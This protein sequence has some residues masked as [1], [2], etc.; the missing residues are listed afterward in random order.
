MVPSADAGDYENTEGVGNVASFD[1]GLI[2]LVD[3]PPAGDPAFAAPAQ[4][5]STLRDVAPRFGIGGALADHKQPWNP[6]IPQARPAPPTSEPRRERT[7]QR[8]GHRS[9]YAKWKSMHS[10]G[11]PQAR[12]CSV[13][14]DDRR[15]PDHPR[16][17]RKRYDFCQCSD[18]YPS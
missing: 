1:A 6:A 12:V 16:A 3:P 10:G 13:S 4:A 2:A 11:G 14:E 5:C 7:C 9:S 18:C 15:Q 8:C 17:A